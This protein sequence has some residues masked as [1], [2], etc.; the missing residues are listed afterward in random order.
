MKIYKLLI[1]IS[2][3][4]SSFSQTK[5]EI[6]FHIEND[7]SIVK[8]LKEK[9]IDFSNNEIATLK[10]FKTFAEYSRDGKLIIPEAFFYNSKGEQI[11]NKGRGVNCS[12]EI[13]KLEKISKMKSNPNNTLNDFLTD[14]NIIEN[15]KIIED[16]IDLYI[17][18]T[19]GKFLNTES[20]TSFNWFSKIRKIKDMKIKLLLLNLDI[21]ENWNMTEVQKKTLGLM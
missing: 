17:I 9:K 4:I 15:E 5:V 18:I 3:S 19:W 7:S 8:Y 21:Q 10:S 11:N 20:E 14:I 1:L 6:N 12:S 13:K 2:F 16:N